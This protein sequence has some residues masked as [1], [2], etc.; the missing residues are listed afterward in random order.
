MST[1]RHSPKVGRNDP[2]PCGAGAKY[3]KCCAG[4]AAEAAPARPEEEE[5]TVG[6]AMTVFTG[7]FFQ[8]A[9]AVYSIRNEAA[10]EGALAQLQCVQDDAREA[11]R[12]FLWAAEARSLRFNVRYEEVP[13]HLHPV[14]LATLRSR[15]P[16]RLTLDTR[17]PKRLVAVMSFLAQHLPRGAVRPE[18]AIMLNRLVTAAEGREVTRT[19]DAWLD[20]DARMMEGA[21]EGFRPMLKTALEAKGGPLARAEAVMRKIEDQARQPLPSLE[22]IPMNEDDHNGDFSALSMGL[23]L[24]SVLAVE[25]FKGNTHLTLLDLTERA[26]QELE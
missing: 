18:E 16:G 11:R 13:A 10:L 2:C 5:S 8:P 22:R 23:T 14:I 7:E 17:S 19:L 25:H 3:K 21:G 20:G 1:P 9:R 15:E 6:Q 24:R 26:L 12:V 4:K